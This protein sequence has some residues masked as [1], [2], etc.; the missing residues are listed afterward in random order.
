MQK[1]IIF[2]CLWVMLLLVSMAG[3]NTVWNPAGNGIYPPDV[4]LWS[5]PNNW[6]SGLPGLGT[7]V[8]PLDHKAVWNLADPAECQVIGSDNVCGVLSMGDNGAD[9]PHNAVLRIMPDS[10]LT[11][12][13]TSINP[14]WSWSAIGYNRTG[15]TMI[16]E[17][18]ATV[19]VDAHFRVGNIAGARRSR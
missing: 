16:V 19:D 13:G 10:T 12:A 9:S 1:I 3:A 18:G 7:E 4:G 2:M 6:A 11:I 8:P 14:D 15:N 17:K 5:D